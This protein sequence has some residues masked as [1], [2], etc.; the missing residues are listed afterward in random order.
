[1]RKAAENE[2]GGGGSGNFRF[3]DNRQKYL[4]F[5]TTCDEKW[6]I[7]SRIG[8]E[9]AYL[10]PTPPCLSVFD[11]GMGDGSVLSNVMRH[12]HAQ[13]PTVPFHVVGK[14]ISLEDVRMSLEKVADRFFEHPQM[15]FT[16]TNMF[17]REAPWLRVESGDMS[18]VNWT[19]VALDGTSAHEFAAQIRELHTTLTD[20]WQVRPSKT[21][22]NLIYEK[23]S[24]LVLYRADQRFALERVIPRRGEV[25]FPYDLVIVSQ[26]Y[27]ARASIAFKVDRILE[28]LVRSLAPGGRLLL[29]QSF[30][31]DPG[32]EIIRRI[33]PDETPFEHKCPDLISDLREALG[34]SAGD[35]DFHTDPAAEYKFQYHMYML[36]SEVSGSIGT[37]TLLAAWNAAIYVAQIE[38]SRLAKALEAGTYLEATADVL[39]RHGGLWFNDESFVAVRKERP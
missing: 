14:E 15:V 2:N 11:A 1:M 32:L 30:G 38:D 16:A 33:W 27:R 19:E 12:L 6:V 25:P 35:Y 34:E 17:Y 8:R 22:N 29:V 31:D 10:R 4:L 5:V 36:P 26:P 39:R 37:S 20:G 21:T 9:I 18:S 7:G 28:P 24:V 23:P 13:F 3:Y